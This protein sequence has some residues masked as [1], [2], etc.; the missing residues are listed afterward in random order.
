[1]ID[2]NGVISIAENTG[3]ARK[4]KLIYIKYHHPHHHLQL[5]AIHINIVSPTDNISDI[6]TKPLLPTMHTL[7][8]N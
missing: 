4:R 6:L 5:Y 1:M 3:K 2:N 8:I 7:I